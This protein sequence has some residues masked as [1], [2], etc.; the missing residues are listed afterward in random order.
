MAY[1]DLQNDMVE[2]I[3]DSQVDTTKTQDF[4]RR[5]E[6]K[7]QRDLIAGGNVPRQM[8][9]RLDTTTDSSSAL[10]LPTDFHKAW[11]VKVNG[12]GARY[13]SPSLV[14]SN[15]SGYGDAD[16]VLDYY[17]TLPVLSD[18]NTSNWLLEDGFDVYLW[19]SC[20][21]YVPWGQEDD[22]MA[23]WLQWYQDAMAS[24][25]ATHG[26]EPR[27]AFFGSKAQQYGAQYTIIGET[28]RF[29]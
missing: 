17:Q 13:A 10:T 27:G 28:M 7:I 18:M 23:L 25:K 2:V 3:R 22:V 15:A 12:I 16:V 1:I 9:A 20:L 21:Q 24:L 4:I 26:P 6:F 19:G 29:A 5:A 8:L 14:D 11:S